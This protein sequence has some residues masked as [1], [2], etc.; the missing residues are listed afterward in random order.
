M[1]SD[2]RHEIPLDAKIYIA[3]HSGLAGSGIWRAFESEGYTNLVGRRSAEL[4]LMDRDATADFFSDERPDYVIDAAARVGGIFDN[5]AHK[6]DFMSQ[7][8]RIQLNVLDAAARFR[9]KRL[10]FLGSNCIYPKFAEQP[11]RE[12]SLMTGELEESNDAYAVAKIAG[13]F[14][15]KA[16]RQQYGMSAISAM[17]TN[18][19]GPGDNFNIP[20]AHAF[21][22]LLRRL[23]EAKLAGDGEFVIYGSGTP[24]REFL[25]TDDLGR[26][27]VHLLRHYDDASPIN[28]GTGVG[29]EINDLVARMAEVIGYDGTFEHDLSKLD[30]TPKKI[31]DIGRISAL[32]WRPR[33]D[34]AEGIKSTYA[35]FVEHQ[36]TFR[37]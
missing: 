32:G 16:L 30:G 35:W 36:D 6:A 14:H 8:L 22:M 31:S 28:V 3:G 11:I 13:V 10:L 20:G 7:N 15:V 4:D 33:I 18:L 27:V 21:P 26:A 2:F 19:Y 37:R 29:T 1:G 34:V 24:I 23:H 5:A 25:H 9:P 17:P 12:D